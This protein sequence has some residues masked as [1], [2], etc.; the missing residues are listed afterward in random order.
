MR[1]ERTW[2]IEKKHNDD[3]VRG[4]GISDKKGN[5]DIHTVIICI[6]FKG[7]AALNIY[8]LGLLI[9]IKKLLINY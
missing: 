5:K 7:S 2:V 4:S 6:D 9:L 1:E 8:V 3:Y